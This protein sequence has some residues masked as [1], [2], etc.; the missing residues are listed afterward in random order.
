M[1]LF[2]QSLLLTL[3]VKSMLYSMVLTTQA[4]LIQVVEVLEDHP[5]EVPEDH[6]V[7]VHQDVPPKHVHVQD[8]LDGMEQ[9]VCV[10]H[11]DVTVNV[12]HHQAVVVVFLSA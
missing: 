11:R 12:V 7:E 1:D 2:K 3:K 5:V 8:V 9:H 6:P 10:I 4:A